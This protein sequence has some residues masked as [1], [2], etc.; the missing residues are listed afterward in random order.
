[1]N[2]R[3]NIILKTILLATFTFTAPSFSED[4]EFLENNCIGDIIKQKARQ[5]KVVSPAGLVNVCRFVANYIIQYDKLPPGYLLPKY[6]SVDVR[7][8][9][10]EFYGEW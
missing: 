2:K 6:T 1:M 7:D 9:R 3:K 5:G 10:E 4:R 8:M